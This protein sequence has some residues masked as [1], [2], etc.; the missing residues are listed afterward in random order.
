[1]ND[2]FDSRVAGLTKSRFISDTVNVIEAAKQTTHGMNQFELLMIA[3][4][5]LIGVAMKNASKQAKGHTP[6]RRTRQKGHALKK[7]GRHVLGRQLRTPEPSRGR[8]EQKI[9]GEVLV[10]ARLANLATQ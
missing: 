8:Q 2:G 5:S 3:N 6:S 1:M 10:A 4:H 7:S 9:L